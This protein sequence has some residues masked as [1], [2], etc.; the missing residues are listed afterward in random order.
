MKKLIVTVLFTTGFSFFNLQATKP[1]KEMWGKTIECSYPRYN[2]DKPI[3]SARRKGLENNIGMCPDNA[4]D[5]NE[6][7]TN[8][9]TLKYLEYDDDD[10]YSSDNEYGSTV[11][12]VFICNVKDLYDYRF[13]YSTTV[14]DA[15]DKILKEGN[16]APTVR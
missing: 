1:P 13:V 15:W 7:C 8:K 16:Y 5:A 3:K 12:D 11:P 6:R 4:F 14:S 2:P 10:G 9:A